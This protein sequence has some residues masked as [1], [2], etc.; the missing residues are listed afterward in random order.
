MIV[1]EL[2]ARLKS[3]ISDKL[4]LLYGS[5]NYLRNH[6][7]NL[8][9]QGL[10][11]ELT[12]FNTLFIKNDKLNLDTIHAFIESP[13]FLSDNKLLYIQNSDLFKSSN[14]AEKEYWKAAFTNL[15][16][17]LTIIFSEENADKRSALYKLADKTGAVVEFKTVDTNTI[18]SFLLLETKKHNKIMDKETMLYFIDKVGDQLDNVVSELAKLLSYCQNKHITKIEIDNVVSTTLQNRVFDM[19]D[20]IM[21]KNVSKAFIILKE[22]KALK[23][24]YQ[25]I[26]YLTVMSFEKILKAKLY[27]D[28]KL[29]IPTI[30]SAM[31]LSPFIA[32]KYITIAQKYPKD[33]LTSIMKSFAQTDY[34]L[35]SGIGNEW[36][37]YEKM[38]L[39]AAKK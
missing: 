1:K 5:E 6:Y 29:P 16:S 19:I 23:E 36:L 39:S 10:S 13:P 12:E 31:E 15:P 2:K 14:D 30:I 28:K 17:Y 18:C 27:S 38:I 22:I 11:I 4:Y 20:A 26:S 3:Q 21:E 7:F 37:A 8:I 25:K 34:D 9:Y 32:K 24:P 33:K 35:R